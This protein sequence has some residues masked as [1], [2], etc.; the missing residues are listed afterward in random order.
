MKK[1][2]VLLMVLVMV[3]T[4]AACGKENSNQVYDW[5]NSGNYGS[6]YGSNYS[7]NYG[8]NYGSYSSS[9]EKCIE[10][11]WRTVEDGRMYCDQCLYGTCLECGKKLDY[12]KRS[13]YCDSCK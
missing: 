4:F 10:C 13:L 5:Q 3:L 12:T 11:G 7:G 8:S 1:I 6:N 9:G 2:L